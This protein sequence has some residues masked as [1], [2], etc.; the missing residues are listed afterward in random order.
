LAGA[1]TTFTTQRLFPPTFTWAGTVSLMGLTSH[2]FFNP[3]LVGTPTIYIGQT[4]TTI[5]GAL[6]VASGATLTVSSVTVS[7]SLASA[8]AING[9]GSF[10]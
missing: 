5:G 9:P 6:T 8:L 1:T 3:T 4:G 10:V 7:W 2:T